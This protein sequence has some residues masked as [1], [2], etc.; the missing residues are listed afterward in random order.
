MPRF[1]ALVAV[2]ASLF[3]TLVGCGTHEPAEVS[4]A[5]LDEHRVQMEEISARERGG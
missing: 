5:A 3:A 2:A 1:V 4:P